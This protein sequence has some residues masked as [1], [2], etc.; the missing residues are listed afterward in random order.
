MNATSRTGVDWKKGTRERRQWEGQALLSKNSGSWWESAERGSWGER[1]ETRHRG[2]HEAT[3]SRSD[4]VSTINVQLNLGQTLI[5]GLQDDARPALSCA[6]QHTSAWPL[7]YRFPR[8]TPRFY[9]YT[10]CLTKTTR[11]KS[12]IYLL[13]RTRIHTRQFE[14]TK[15]QRTL[16]GE[17]FKIHISIT[18]GNK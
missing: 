7:H 8:S 11:H 14:S 9:R 15:I 12:N 3:V 18:I 17:Y 4:N 6:T 13:Y 10:F 1:T 5:C 16:K 2:W